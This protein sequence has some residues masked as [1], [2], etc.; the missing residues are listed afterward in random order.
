MEEQPAPVLIIKTRGDS[1]IIVHNGISLLNDSYNNVRKLFRKL[2]DSVGVT[3]EYEGLER[4][5]YGVEPTGPQG[6]Y[7]TKN[8]VRGLR[9]ALFPL[10]VPDGQHKWRSQIEKD[11][12]ALLR[13]EKPHAS[14]ICLSLPAG[15]GDPDVDFDLEPSRDNSAGLGLA[16]AVPFTVPMARSRHFFGRDRF[17]AHLHDYLA[18][19]DTACVAVCGSGGMGKSQ[20]AAEYAHAHRDRY[21]RGVF[22]V[23]AKDLQSVQEE[24][25]RL[26]R[27]CEDL[28]APPELS[29]EECARYVR[30]RFQQLDA[31]ALLILDNLDLDAKL[32]PLLP[33][34]GC[35]RILAT[36]RRHSRLKSRFHVMTLPTLDSRAAGQALQ[37][38]CTIEETAAR[39]AA[40]EPGCSLAVALERERAAV[41]GINDD[42][43]QRL[44]LALT[45]IAFYVDQ[46]KTTFEECRRR[47]HANSYKVFDGVEASYSI[48]DAFRVSQDELS[49][50]ALCILAAAACFGR[51]NISPD[52]LRAVAGIEDIETFED[53]IVQLDGS[54]F[55]SMDDGGRV[56]LHDVLRDITFKQ[57]EEEERNALLQRTAEALLAYLERMN[58]AMT[59]ESV[60]AEIAQSRAVIEHCRQHRLYAPL[61]SLLC[62]LGNYYRLHDE[63]QAA[64]GYVHEAAA[65]VAAHLPHAGE[66]RAK[67]KMH[68][69]VADPLAPAA[70]KNAR[71]ALALVRGEGVASDA[72]IA[73]YY[74]VVGYVLLKAHRRSWRALPFYSRALQLC[75]AVSGRRCALAGEY[76]NN[77]GVLYEGVGDLAKAAEYLSEAREILQ[78]VHGQAHR[79]SAIVINNLGR[80][81][82]ALG[83]SERALASH[84]Q[85][86]GIHDSLYGRENKDYAMSLY[87][88]AMALADLGRAEEAEA[89]GRIA[90]DILDRKYG[91]EDGAGCRVRA[92][93]DGLRL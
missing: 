82:R 24:Y 37:A 39:L 52:L 63:M 22:W 68:I 46:R 67:C 93:L 80:V 48:H 13:L 27:E 2:I 85:A 23:D 42:L 53:A 79:Q 81:Q 29:V 76:L 91:R 77:I 86:Q 43:N 33:V 21:P 20:L 69:A 56:T 64:L 54:S 25:A 41:Q 57:I 28:R 92:W 3:L 90:L 31:P 32:L 73:E 34:T 4:E 26:S 1:C 38:C 62:E 50:G 35:C 17:V 10:D 60:G 8:A 6:A 88:A 11:G 70:L 72:L 5:V 49:E 89:E 36:T 84:R 58:A 55:V 44:P 71:Q 18:S 16:A 7:N 14:R 66:L 61:A 30:E 83:D 40:R 47:L 9:S 59:W 75:E 15:A 19:S 12:K 74:N 87:F 45:L 78:Q 65:I 51:Q